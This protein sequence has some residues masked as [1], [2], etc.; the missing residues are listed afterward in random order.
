MKDHIVYRLTS[1]SGKVY[2]GV[3]KL[4]IKKRIGLHLTS[5]TVVG[6]ALRKYGVENF[7]TETVTTGSRAKCYAAEEMLVTFDKSKS[8]NIAPGGGGGGFEGTCPTPELVAAAKAKAAAGVRTPEY[9]ANR[10]VQSAKFGARPEV[11]TARRKGMLKRWAT[12]SHKQK[13]KAGHD[14]AF[15]R[16]AEQDLLGD[17]LKNADACA[18]YT[19]D[20][21]TSVLAARFGVTEATV[22]DVRKGRIFAHA[23]DELPAP[24]YWKSVG[25]WLAHITQ[26][27]HVRRWKKWMLN[28]N[29]RAKL[30]EANK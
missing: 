19:S 15:K 14:A 25:S 30:K 28:K 4:G 1:P 10:S 20:L 18:I 13:R 21:P 12:D 8:Y 3:T 23:T 9:R 6:H 16:L 2:V 5:D 27:H 11:K 22:C 26:D 29:A 17:K 24:V 7:K